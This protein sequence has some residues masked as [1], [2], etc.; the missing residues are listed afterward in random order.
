MPIDLEKSLGELRS[1]LL[2]LGSRVEKRLLDV[3]D[4]LVNND[5][6]LAQEVKVGDA[7]IDM[8]DR[9]IEEECMRLLALGAPVAS[10]LRRLIMVMKISGELERIG[11]LVKGVSKRVIRLADMTDVPLPP[12]LI[13]MGDATRSI[14]RDALAALVENDVTMARQVRADDDLIDDLNK[15]ILRWAREDVP[16]DPSLVMMAIEV[17]AIA[18]R[19]ERIGDLTSAMAEEV[20]FVVEGRSVRHQRD[21]AE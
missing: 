13:Q 19:F 10:D 4:A 2:V 15:T 21:L 9:R 3:T 16:Q 7:E 20:I 14:L 5:R 18:Q 8:E 11:D 6:A 12:A 1:S 17:L